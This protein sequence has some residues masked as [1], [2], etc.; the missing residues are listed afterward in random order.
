MLPSVRARLEAHQVKLLGKITT[1]AGAADTRTLF[2]LNEE[3]RR[4]DSLLRRM[5]DIGAEARALLSFESQ[6]SPRPP[7]QDGARLVQPPVSG[8][9]IGI[10]VRSDFLDRAAIAGLF[11]KPHRGSVYAGPSGRRIGIAVATEVKPNRWFL[12]LGEN[13]FDAAVLLCVPASGRVIDICLPQSFIAQQM[14]FFSRSGGQIKFNVARR[15]GQTILKIPTRAPELVDQFIASI[16][17]L[18]R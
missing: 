13:D 16:V 17:G 15:S 11:L 2:A 12:G 18:D 9:G 6:G 3:L 1:A 7:E 10:K 5:D 14:P 8:R 4:T